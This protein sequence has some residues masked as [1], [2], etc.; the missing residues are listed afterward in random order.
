MNNNTSCLEAFTVSF[1][2]KLDFLICNSRYIQDSTVVYSHSWG[3]KEGRSNQN[4]SRM[5]V[6]IVIHIFGKSK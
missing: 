3:K 5:R 1:E 4:A 6:T 2:E